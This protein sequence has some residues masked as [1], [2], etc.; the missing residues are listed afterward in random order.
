MAGRQTWTSLRDY[1]DSCKV[2]KELTTRFVAA[3]TFYLVLDPLFLQRSRK[4]WKAAK[5]LKGSKL[6]FQLLL[7]CYLFSLHF[8]STTV[9][10][11]ESLWGI[12]MTAAK[13]LKSSQL[14]LQLLLHFTL[15]LIHFSSSA[16]GKFEPLWGIIMTAAKLLKSSQLDF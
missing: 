11:L 5:L 13:L 14:D 2:V 15:F 10:K 6:D 12:I 16:V 7:Y 4:I 3:F 8:S 9:G 1:H